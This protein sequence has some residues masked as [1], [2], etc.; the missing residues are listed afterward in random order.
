[1]LNVSVNRYNATSRKL[2]KKIGLVFLFLIACLKL[3][4]QIEDLQ[5]AMQFSRNGE[6]QKANDIYQKLYKQ[7]NEGYFQFYFKSLLS[8]KKFDEAESVTKKLIRKHP[9]EYQYTVALGTVYYEKGAKDKAEAVFN[10]L[11]KNMQPQQTIVNEI[12]MQ[13]YQAE[14]IDFAI[15][16]FVQGRKIL[17]NDDL[18]SNELTSLYRYKHDKVNLVNEYISLLQH[19]PEFIMAAKNGISMLFDSADDYNM[20]K[21]ALLPAANHLCRSVNLAIPAAKTV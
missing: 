13:F 15:K 7:S 18:Y 4:A 10:D 1:M 19:R 17:H 20:L 11:I 16:A 21:A 3:S 2:I 8:L 9:E 5:L 6:P 12:A 14:Q